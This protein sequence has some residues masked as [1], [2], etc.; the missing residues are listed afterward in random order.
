MISVIHFFGSFC[1]TTGRLPDL[2]SRLLLTM[3]A[4]LTSSY[5][6]NNVG[7]GHGKATIFHYLTGQ[8]YSIM[9]EKM[10]WPLTCIPE[11][12]TMF[13]RTY[14]KKADSDELANGRTSEE[15]RDG[16][17][18]QEELRQNSD[19]RYL[20][21][22]KDWWYTFLYE[23]ENQQMFSLCKDFDKLSLEDKLLR[24]QG[25]ESADVQ[26]DTVQPETVVTNEYANDSIWIL[27]SLYGYFNDNGDNG[28]NSFIERVR[29]R[30]RELPPELLEWLKTPAITTPPAI[31][32]DFNYKSF[33]GNSAQLTPL[34]N[35]QFTLYKSSDIDILRL[36]SR[37]LGL[38]K[39]TDSWNKWDIVNMISIHSLKDVVLWD[40]Q[41]ILVYVCT[42]YNNKYGR[43]LV[44][45]ILGIGCIVWYSFGPITTTP[46]EFMRIFPR[47]E[48]VSPFFNPDYTTPLLQEKL[49]FVEAS[50]VTEKVGVL[51]QNI[52]PFNTLEIPATGATMTAVGLGIIVA[53]LL[54]VGF[55]PECT[56]AM[57]ELGCSSALK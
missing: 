41:K 49:Q 1:K 48:D 20:D 16:Y 14:D 10:N 47:I 23:F 17:N 13:V 31:K 22:E 34:T 52:P 6:T 21:I 26:P 9:A 33:L 11:Y 7:A 51:V 30:P 32:I 42:K 19:M 25:S 37:D 3:K 8:R 29:Y 4:T 40:V 36:I 27:L 2:N 57:L 44:L 5:S 46:E 53:T 54:T 56:S 43:F 24:E 28:D 18:E 15:L 12:T 35:H 50:D 38:T 55:V 45:V 39:Y